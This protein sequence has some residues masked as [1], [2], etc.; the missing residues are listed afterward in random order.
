[1][2]ILLGHISLTSPDLNPYD[3]RGLH[4]G[5]PVENARTQGLL[6]RCR[7]SMNYDIPYQSCMPSRAFWAE[8]VAGSEMFSPEIRIDSIGMI[9]FQFATDIA[10]FDALKAAYTAKYGESCATHQEDL[11]NL[12]GATFR[13]EVITWCFSDGKMSLSKYLKAN[14]TKSETVFVSQ[15][16]LN[17]ANQSP[18]DVNF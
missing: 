5:L 4:T 14:V 8:P 2:A 1:M 3:F 15:R 11:Q 13:Q 9:A 12:Y 16:F 7:A 17:A 10:H 18:P 6:G